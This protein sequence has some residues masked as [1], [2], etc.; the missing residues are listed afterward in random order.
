M[1]DGVKLPKGFKLDT[2][3]KAPKGFVLDSPETATAEPKKRDFSEAGKYG[4]G[5]DA[6]APSPK[7]AQQTFSMTDYLSGKPGSGVSKPAVNKA[8]VKIGAAV[9]VDKNKP[10]GN[11][12]AGVYNTLVK[13]VSRLAGGTAYAIGSSPNAMV[14]QTAKS[15]LT[16]EGHSLTRDAEKM[17]Q[18]TVEFVEQARSSAS[19]KQ[20]EQERSQFDVTDGVSAKDVE[21][22]VFQAPS[23]LLDMVAGAVTAGGSFALQAINDNA[24]E[25]ASN[26]NAEKLSDAEKLGYVYTQAAVQAA[27]EKFAIDKI[28]KSTGLTKKAKQKIAAE[29][30]EQF[31]KSGTKATAEQIERAALAKASSLASKIKRIGVKGTTGVGVESATEA[32]QSASSDGIKLLTNKLT[33]QEV[34]DEEDITKNF[35]KN[36]INASV[37]GG[38]FG[39]I[40]GGGAGVLSNTKKAIRDGIAKATNPEDVAEIQRQIA[41]Q[42]E[43]GNLTPEEA[44]AANI[45]AKQYAEIAAKIP[46]HI[47]SKKKYAIIGGIEQRENLN[48]EIETA[49]AEMQNTDPAF[50]KEIADRVQ[51]LEEKK[52]QT[53][54]YLNDLISDTPTTYKEVEGKFFKVDANGEET[55]IGRTHYELATAIKQEDKRKAA[56]AEPVVTPEDKTFVEDTDAKIQQRIEELDKKPSFIG[57]VLGK[58]TRKQAEELKANPEKYFD[59]L[60]KD[61]PERKDEILAEKER[62]LSVKEKLPKPSPFNV[63]ELIKWTRDFISD[64][65]ESE[66]KVANTADLVKIKKFETNAPQA[67]EA[68]SVSTMSKEGVKTP[69]VILEDANGNQQ[70]QQGHH[71]LEEAA[72]IGMKELPVVVIKTNDTLPANG[73]IETKPLLESPIEVQEPERSV[74]TE[75]TPETPE[76]EATKQPNPQFEANNQKAQEYGYDNAPQAINSVAKRLGKKYDKFEDIPAE[77]LQAAVDQR[78]AEKRTANGYVSKS[79]KQKIIFEGGITKVIDSK[80]G[81]EVSGKTAKKVIREAAENL[82]YNTGDRSDAKQPPRFRDENEA[83]DWVIDNSR[84]AVEI[85]EVFVGEKPEQVGLSST[86]QMIADYGVG[87][88]TGESYNRHGDRNNMNNS[89]AR[90]YLSK[91][92]QPI[93]VVAKEMSDHYG[94]EITVQDIVDFM[95]RFPNGEGSALK[96]QETNISLRAK[97]KFQE[98]T[99]LPLNEE[100]ATAAINSEFRNLSKSEQKLAEQ[101]YETRQQLEDAYWQAF[102]ETDGFTKEGATPETKQGEVKARENELAPLDHIPINEPITNRD[103]AEQIAEKILSFRSDRS[104][105]YGGITGVTVAIYDGMLTAAANAVRLGGSVLDAVNAAVDY[106]KQNAPKADLDRTRKFLNDLFGIA[107]PKPAPPSANGIMKGVDVADTAKRTAAMNQSMNELNDGIKKLRLSWWDKFAK[108]SFEGQQEIIKRLN[109]LGQAGK[110]AV[111][112]LITSKGSAAKAEAMYD[113]ARKVIYGGIK[114]FSKVK[115]GGTEVRVHELLNRVVTLKRVI[116]IDSK[117][118]EKFLQFETL[119]ADIASRQKANPNDPALPKLKAQYFQVKEYLQRNDVLK[120]ENGVYSLGQYRHPL[121][122][123]ADVAKI[124]LANIKKEQPELFVELDKRSQTLSDTFHKLIDMKEEAGIL[125]KEQADSLREY[126]YAPRREIDR[127]ILDETDNSGMKGFGQPAKDRQ[128]IKRLEGG[129][130][131]LLDEHYDIHLQRAINQT[132]KDI[133]LNNAGKKLLEAVRKNPSNE[134]LYENEPIIYERGGMKGQ[135]SRDKFGNVRYREIPEGKA[136][137]RVWEDGKLVEVV[138]DKRLVDSFYDSYKTNDFLAK[139]GVWTGVKVIRGAATGYNPAFGLYQALIDPVTA[140]VATDT[141]KGFTVGIAQIYKDMVVVAKDVFNPKGVS[142]VAKEARDYGAFTSFN[143]GEDVFNMRSDLEVA[144][145]KT[146]R[147]MRKML[148]AVNWLN[149]RVENWTRTAVYLKAKNDRIAKYKKE[150]GKEPSGQD[151]EDIKTLAAQQAR[152]YVDFARGGDY[153]REANSVLPYLNAATQVTRSAIAKA[154]K[155]PVKFSQMTLEATVAGIGVLAYSLGLMGESDEEKKKRLD[156]YRRVNP[157]TRRKFFLIYKEGKDGAPEFIRIAKPPVLHIA[158]NAAEQG[159]L[160]SQFGDDFKVGDVVGDIQ[161]LTPF[162]RALLSRNPTANATLK[163]FGNKDLYFNKEVVRDEENISDYLEGVDDPKTKEFYLWLGKKTH[164][165]GLGEGISPKRLRA[166]VESFM[167]RSDRNPFVNVITNTTGL[168]F[169][170]VTGNSKSAT[171]K[172]SELGEAKTYLDATALPDRFVIKPSDFDIVKIEKSKEKRK[173]STDSRVIRRGKAI[174]RGD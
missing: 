173:A 149:G 20:D 109:S 129:S 11:A 152:S 119:R 3:V 158:I 114:G 80:T 123:T 65:P 140:V 10:K 162:D 87:K 92:G 68:E 25:L 124:D 104:N 120:Y 105:L 27:L 57:K 98:L 77:E 22:L 63:P 150:N 76:V 53:E 145:E 172:L 163:Y 14:Y 67:K 110:T 70:L 148:G 130:E 137:I 116:S 19:T 169:D 37:Q 99:G 97:E 170:L 102:K 26:A 93:D 4:I 45:T 39:G 171:N 136:V 83:K 7:P 59:Q 47:D 58:D 91:D 164:D 31:V 71:R 16:G 12:L 72:R 94:V 151:L 153:V 55:E 95:D 28:L 89:K 9:K 154:A 142:G 5:T 61:Q 117:M 21:S 156:A 125:S 165:A 1:P 56:P 18:G 23:Q 79:G 147:G 161:S 122:Y 41:E 111:A 121:G 86:E 112:Y 106:V 62:Y 38:A 174:G 82:D 13:S 35:V 96:L 127:L 36:I 6:D 131:G 32:L 34:F 49:K 113:A 48:R 90:T 8:G 69:L 108:R 141:Y 52:A 51:V 115:I 33:G 29:I 118:R 88:V 143:R 132:L 74:A 133:A 15:L 128:G 78:K 40:F 17:R 42:V 167:G 81:E 159:L 24:E 50:A 103:R 134:Y 107:N 2:E 100:T 43:E 101:E 166:S 64:N 138:G 85:A 135:L 46:A 157:E 139:L 146:R 44:E 60:A 73:K 75:A 160:A 155:N 30:T 84:N 126:Y 144:K 54:D 168:A 66:L